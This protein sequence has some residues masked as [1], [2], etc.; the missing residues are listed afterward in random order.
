M[1]NKELVD[2]LERLEAAVYGEDSRWK[3][4]PWKPLINGLGDE[5]EVEAPT[6]EEV[7]TLLDKLQDT[8]EKAASYGLGRAADYFNERSSEV[9][10]CAAAVEALRKAGV[11]TNV[12]AFEDI[13][14]SPDDDSKT[15]ECRYDSSLQYR[16]EI[17]EYRLPRLAFDVGDEVFVTCP[18]YYGTTIKPKSEGTRYKLSDAAAMKE[19][20]LNHVMPAKPNDLIN[21]AMPALMAKFKEL[22][23]G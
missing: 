21:E 19:F 22:R 14:M 15:I 12:R 9:R 8:L 18:Q 6:S 10:A 16:V 17:P 13:R 1:K 3:P 20:L 23:N 7:E 5:G 2:R 11:A 4:R